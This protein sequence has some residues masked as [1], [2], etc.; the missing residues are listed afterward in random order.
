M[1]T[2]LDPPRG[3]FTFDEE[4]HAY[5]LKGF[6]VPSVTQIIKEVLGIKFEA[7]DWYKDLG[8]ANHAGYAMLAA[9]K[10]F[11]CDPA[12]EGYMEAWRRWARDHK[13][14]PITWE[15]PVYSS[16]FQ[17]A[18]MLDLEAVVD[19]VHCITDFKGSLEGRIEWQLAGYTL[20]FKVPVK[21]GL[22]VEFDPVTF[23]SKMRWFKDI[24]RR[25]SNQFKAM[26]EVYGM[27][28]AL[29]EINKEI[30]A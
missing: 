13:V 19:G 18:G 12:C 6:R 26:R 17:F 1:I 8:K 22:G 30:S 7:S 5:F 11:E 20:C 3:D 28:Q 4:Q 14:Q 25:P 2:I 27:K 9:G 10:D 15:R 23:Q 16:L 29:G 24:H 21:T